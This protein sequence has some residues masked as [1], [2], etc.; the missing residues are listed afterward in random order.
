M[1]RR[2]SG[3]ERPCVSLREG[4]RG[5]SALC[6]FACVCVVDESG[7]RRRVG[8]GGWM[9]EGRSEVRGRRKARWGER[10]KKAMAARRRGGETR[11]E[12]KQKW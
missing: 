11:K 3:P 2:G 12:E 4:K 6:V 5:N 8:D 1:N 9:M 7:W 10:E